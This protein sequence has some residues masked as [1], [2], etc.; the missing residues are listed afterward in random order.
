MCAGPATPLEHVLFL[1]VLHSTTPRNATNVLPTKAT[2]LCLCLSENIIIPIIF[3]K[4]FIALPIRIVILDHF[5]THLPF[6]G[7]HPSNIVG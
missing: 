7:P 6:S 4:V 5:G 2:R 3:A 1:K